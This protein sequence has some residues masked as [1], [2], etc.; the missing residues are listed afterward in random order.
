[1]L[2][3]THLPKYRPFWLGAKRNK[4][5]SEVFNWVDGMTMLYTYWGKTYPRDEGDCLSVDHDTGVWK[6][7]DC[8]QLDGF[9][10]RTEKG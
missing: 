10:C 1:M 9:V 7:Q 5:R 6:N 3:R 4:T 8:S 2:A